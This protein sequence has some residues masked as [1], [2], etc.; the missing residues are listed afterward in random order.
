MLALKNHSKET[1]MSDITKL[2]VWAQKEISRLRARV[3]ELEENVSALMGEMPK[4]PIAVRNIYAETPVPVAWSPY[5]AISFSST[6][7]PF[8]E[9]GSPREGIINARVVNGALELT[10]LDGMLAIEP[11]ASNVIRLQVTSF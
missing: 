5:E 9:I 1:A 11:R 7:E 2:P 4:E 10:A 8:G 6:G 3:G